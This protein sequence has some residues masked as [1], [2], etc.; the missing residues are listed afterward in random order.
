MK[1][2]KEK[3]EKP[4][5][6]TVFLAL[7]EDFLDGA[8]KLQCELQ[9]L[10]QASE[11]VLDYTDRVKGRIGELKQSA[12]VLW[13]NHSALCSIVDKAGFDT[14]LELDRLRVNL[15][16]ATKATGQLAADLAESGIPLVL[17]PKPNG[18]GLLH[19]RGFE[20]ALSPKEFLFVETLCRADEKGKEGWVGMEFLERALSVNRGYLAT[21]KGRVAE[22]LEATRDPALPHLISSRPNEYRVNGYLK[23]SP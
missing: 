4:S 16:K 15:G 13:S 8:K 14:V 7:F 10:E 11:K 3:S 6:E 5:A 22:K 9:E 19:A 2:R 18:G 23:D 20:L 12:R 1:E 21:I 17:D